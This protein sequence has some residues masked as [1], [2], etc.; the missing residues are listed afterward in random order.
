MTI[1][2]IPATITMKWLQVSSETALFGDR[3]CAYAIWVL[4][5]NIHFLYASHTVNSVFATLAEF[6]VH[7][8]VRAFI[9]PQEHCPIGH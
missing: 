4:G 7:L 9:L 3:V 5:L 8:P 2:V 1:T 6:P